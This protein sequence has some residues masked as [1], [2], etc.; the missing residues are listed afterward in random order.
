MCYFRYLFWTEAKPRIAKIE[1]G[2]MDGSHR[3]TL[4][5]TLLGSPVD[6]VV[7]HVE[8]RLYWIDNVVSLRSNQL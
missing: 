8:S 5:D 1:R 2:W 4:V 7:D 3:T 6:I